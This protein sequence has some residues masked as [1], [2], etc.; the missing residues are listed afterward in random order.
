MLLRTIYF[1]LFCVFFNIVIQ[2]QKKTDSLKLA[3]KTCTVDSQKIK[4]LNELGKQFAYKLPDSAISYLKLA[5]SLAGGDELNGI[6]I[7][8]NFYFGLSYNTKASYDNAEYYFLKAIQQAR[9]YKKINLEAAANLGLGTTYNFWKK[10]PKALE[11][12]LNALKLYKNI[13]DSGRIAAVSLGLGN[14]YSDI[15]NKEKA[16]TYFNECLAISMARKD[17]SYISRCYNNIGNLY[18]KNK[19]YEKALEYF[20]KSL[21]LKKILKDEHGIA[22]TYTNL[23]NVY[24]LTNKQ[25][26]AKFFYNTAKDTYLSLGDSVQYKNTLLALAECFI[27]E[28]NMK[29]AL[30]NVKEAE[31]IC[32]RNKYN[33]DLAPVYVLLTRLYILKGDTANARISLD[34][35][36]AVKDS[37]LSQDMNRQ[38]AEMTARFESDIQKQ[39]ISLQEAELL[40]SKK[41]NTVYILTTT[42]FILLVIF[43]LILIARNKKSQRLLAE[44]HKTT[45]IKNKTAWHRAN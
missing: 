3:L 30:I 22:N 31:Q 36:L 13:S 24:M 14:V 44:Q 37:I 18:E 2:A 4:I 21:D 19:E 25:S 7:N 26:L 11:S 28:H 12:Y 45:G 20:T 16:L 23:A 38:I 29:Q 5:K 10:Q 6:C 39:K 17:T 35:Y 42:I 32:K 1:L 41:L 43:L 27:S 15:E 9:K 40:A 33:E 8:T 34:D